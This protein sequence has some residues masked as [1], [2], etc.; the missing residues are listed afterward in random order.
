MST[1]DFSF[2]HNIP[3]NDDPDA[4]LIKHLKPW[5]YPTNIL[6]SKKQPWGNHHYA[7]EWVGVCY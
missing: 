5:S 6:W 2:Y 7:G 4:I 3:Q 1:V